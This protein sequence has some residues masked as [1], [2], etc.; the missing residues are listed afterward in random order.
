METN[1]YREIV[2]KG[3]PFGSFCR[4]GAYSE[5]TRQPFHGGYAANLD[6]LKFY[7]LSSWELSKLISVKVVSTLKPVFHTFISLIWAKKT[8]SQLPLVLF[9]TVI[10]CNMCKTQTLYHWLANVTP[11]SRYHSSVLSNIAL[12]LQLFGV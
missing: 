5:M 7:L 1:P 9:S 6:I 2:S 8:V 3:N 12:K 10:T 11:R 4:V